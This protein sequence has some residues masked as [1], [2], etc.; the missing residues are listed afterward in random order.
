[1]RKFAAF[2]V[3][4]LLA[5]CFKVGPDYQKPPID[6]PGRWRFDDREARDLRNSK[7]W[8]QFRDPVLNGLMEKAFRGNLDLKIAAARVEEFMGLYGSTRSN[9]FPQFSGN[10]EYQRRKNSNQV[11]NFPVDWSECCSST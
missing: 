8:E 2:A 9:L 3:S 11:G 7:W 6:V 5:G 1:M 10:A 4:A